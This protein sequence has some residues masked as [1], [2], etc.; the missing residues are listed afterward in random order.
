MFG[1]YPARDG[2]ARGELGR[3]A[4]PAG[5]E[6]AGLGDEKEEGPEDEGGEVDRLQRGVDQAKGVTCVLP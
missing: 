5:G 1:R 3:L 6:E 2:A 4:V